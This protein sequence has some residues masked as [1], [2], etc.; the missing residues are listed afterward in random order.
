[1][2]QK[3]EIVRSLAQ[4]LAQLYR[5]RF[6]KIGSLVYE[7]STDTPQLVRFKSLRTRFLEGLVRLFFWSAIAWLH[8]VA[9]SFSAPFISTKPLPKSESKIVVG[10]DSTITNPGLGRGPFLKPYDWLQVRLQQ[11]VRTALMAAHTPGCSTEEHVEIMSEALRWKN[12]IYRRRD[13]SLKRLEPSSATS[14]YHPI[15]ASTVLISENG[16]LTGFTNWDTI[17]VWPCWAVT[18]LPEALISREILEEP[19]LAEFIDLDR[20]DDRPLESHAC[21]SEAY[22]ASNARLAMTRSTQGFDRYPDEARVRPYWDR[23]E[24]Y[25]KTKLRDLFLSRMKDLAPGW[26][27]IRVK[28]KRKRLI[29]RIV[30]D[31]NHHTKRVCDDWLEP[32]YFDPEVA[33]APEDSLGGNEETI[34]PDSDADGNPRS[35]D[36]QTGNGAQVESSHITEG[37]EDSD[38]DVDRGDSV[39]IN[40]DKLGDDPAT[41][42]SDSSS[43]ADSLDFSDRE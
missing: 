4:Y 12:H 27:E 16:Q 39:E 2:E 9:T 40:E 10:P 15:R 1:M 30:E 5:I 7:K 42:F 37:D 38:D 26:V 32:T 35:D 20:I 3:E 13:R 31:L 11:A 22:A 29:A 19:T 8:H 24:A 18:G 28:R 43:T 41:Q 33:G 25:E 14:I 23:L 6:D 34:G 21:L 36:E 17:A